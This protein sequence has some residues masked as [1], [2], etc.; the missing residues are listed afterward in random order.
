MSTTN[1]LWTYRTIKGLSISYHICVVWDVK[2]SLSIEIEHWFLSHRYHHSSLHS[3]KWT[4]NERKTIVSNRY[5]LYIARLH[6][7]D[8]VSRLSLIPVASAVSRLCDR[9]P[10]RDVRSTLPIVSSVSVA[11]DFK[12]INSRDNAQTI[13]S[14]ICH[15]FCSYLSSRPSFLLNSPVP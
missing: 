15:A 13:T 7:A 2:A 1:P 8:S 14:S 5:N 6:R 12:P 4:E 11:R 9:D 10:S 3:H